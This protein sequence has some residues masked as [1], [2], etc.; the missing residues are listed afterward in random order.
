MA[1][2]DAETYKDKIEVSLDGRQVFYL[3]FGGAIIACMVFVLGVMVGKRV[4]SRA[5]AGSTAAANTRRDPLA[6]LDRLDAQG[7]QALTFRKALSSGLAPATDVEKAIAEMDRAASAKPAVAPAPAP[8]P[9]A[10]VAPVAAPKAALAAAPAAAPTPKPAAP[11]AAP[12]AA[13]TAAP[14]A[15][16]TKG[17]FTLQLSA[18]Q[19]K[20][21]AEEFLRG[22]KGA[23]FGAYLTE[24]EVS[25]KGTYYRV[26]LG[27]YGTYED[28]V[29]AK[30][31]FEQKQKK[32]AYVTR[33]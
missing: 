28:A 2:A 23:G 25:G 13:P 3:F 32:I 11:A 12:T 15:P 18:F 19:D 26:R 31:A 17:K 1:T 33:L 27:S 22:V 9:V 21:E 30:T 14:A 20:A 24:A 10:S 4:E 8:V 6:A 5:H 29:A 16:A 7:D